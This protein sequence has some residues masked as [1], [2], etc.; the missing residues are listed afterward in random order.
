M[1][2]S[3]ILNMQ[4]VL[5]LGGAP[6]KLIHDGSPFELVLGG[7]GRQWDTSAK[8]KCWGE[9]PVECIT[10]LAPDDQ[11]AWQVSKGDGTLYL[12]CGTT[13][14]PK[15]FNPHRILEALAQSLFLRSC[16]HSENRVMEKPDAY[17]FYITPLYS[18]LGYNVERRMFVDHV[19]VVAVAGN[20]SLRMFALAGGIPGLIRGKACLPCCLDLCREAG[21]KYIVL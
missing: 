19:G 12:A 15:V 9:K 20:D 5:K 10:N 21:L 17:S 7:T 4:G 8:A 1:F 16:V 3:G 13:N 18:D 11:L 6:G 14:T 2:D